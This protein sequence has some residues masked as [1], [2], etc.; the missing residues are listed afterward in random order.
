MKDFSAFLDM[1]SSVQS[2][3]RV[4]T[5]RDPMD[6]STP[7]FPVHH[8]LPE[9]AQTH[10]RQVSDAT[11]QFCPLLSPSLSAFGLTQKQGLFK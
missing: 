9:I 6:Y 2:L 10:V 4:P 1:L 7:G 8:Q 3:S 5:L 11:Q